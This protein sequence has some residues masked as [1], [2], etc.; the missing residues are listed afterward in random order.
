[1]NSSI[2]FVFSAI[3]ASVTVGGKAATKQFAKSH[4]TAIIGFVSKFININE[5]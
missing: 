3:V 2:Q 4:S 1:M 5:K